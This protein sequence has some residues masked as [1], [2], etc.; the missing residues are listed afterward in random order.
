[1]SDLQ[2]ISSTRSQ[3]V[4]GAMGGAHSRLRELAAQYRVC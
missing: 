1:M 4:R 3:A 2:V